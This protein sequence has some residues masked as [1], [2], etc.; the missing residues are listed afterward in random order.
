[1]I[2]VDSSVFWCLE[3]VNMREIWGRL[4]NV[5]DYGVL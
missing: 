3:A 1:M 4:M 5:S 2:R